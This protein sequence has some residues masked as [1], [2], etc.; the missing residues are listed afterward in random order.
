M[1]AGARIYVGA[2]RLEQHVFKSFIDNK[3]EYKFKTAELDLLCE[4][5]CKMHCHFVTAEGD[6][7]HRQTRKVVAAISPK[8]KQVHAASFFLEFSWVTQYASDDNLPKLCNMAPETFAKWCWNHECVPVTPRHGMKTNKAL[9]ANLC[10]HAATEKDKKFQTDIIE[11]YNKRVLKP[12]EC[13]NIVPLLS[14]SDSGNRVKDL[15][16]ELFGKKGYGCLGVK[17]VIECL[18]AHS[19][20]KDVTDNE[21]TYLP[22]GGGALKYW[23]HSETIRPEMTTYVR[24]FFKNLEKSDNL[25]IKYDDN[26]EKDVPFESLGLSLAEITERLTQYWGCCQCRILSVCELLRRGGSSDKIPYHLK[27]NKA[28]HERVERAFQANT[29]SSDEDDE[30]SDADSE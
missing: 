16:K 20:L 4:T 13:K 6:L 12:D 25:K 5:M 30:S 26:T 27:P 2:K 10:E 14:Q 19:L 23:N 11:F 17:N 3:E 22:D 28:I 24:K 15:R 7:M 18:A 9:H 8:W 29:E 1:F 21:W